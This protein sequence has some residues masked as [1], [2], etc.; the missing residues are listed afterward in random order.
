[1]RHAL[2][3]RRELL[4]N[5]TALFT[6]GLLGSGL[7]DVFAGS[8]GRFNIGACDWSIG[9][10]GK[11]GAMALARQLGIDGAQVSMGNVESD[12]HL[13]RPDVQRAYRLESYIEN[14]RFMRAQF[15]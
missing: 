7:R 11:T 5:T 14:A 15:T 10:R 4:K 9:M 1:M 8:R 6:A 3:S 13:R 2:P 12:L